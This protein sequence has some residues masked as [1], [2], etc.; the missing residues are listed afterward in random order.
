M[1]ETFDPARMGFNM[2]AAS[3]GAPSALPAPQSRCASS[4]KRIAG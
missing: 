3:M 1:T 4:M 2:F